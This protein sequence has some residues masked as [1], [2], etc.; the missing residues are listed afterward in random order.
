MQATYATPQFTR[1]PERTTT[2]QLAEALFWVYKLYVG[3]IAVYFGEIPNLG[4]L[5]LMV[6]TA[7]ILFSVYPLRVFE[8][9]A[10]TLVA[11]IIIYLQFV[12]VFVHRDFSLDLIIKSITWIGLTICFS[13]FIKRPGFV[14]R[15]ILYMFLVGV[16]AFLNSTTDELGRMSA[17]AGLLGNANTFGY[18]LGFCAITLTMWAISAKRLLPKL[19]LF[20]M[21]GF[22]YYIALSSVS[23]GTLLAVAV[24]MFVFA[25]VYVPV[26]MPLR[27]T[28]L[29]VFVLGI[30]GLI[31]VS[32]PFFA[33]ISEN[34]QNRLDRDTGRSSLW[35]A[36]VDSVFE[37]PI[38]GRGEAGVV[39]NAGRWTNTS[40]HNPFLTL[41]SISGVF[42]GFMLACLFI[43]A[44][45]RMRKFAL[46]E[47][48]FWL[49]SLWVFTIIAISSSN[50][51]FLND[52]AIMT[53]VLCLDGVTA[54]RAEPAPPIPTAT[55]RRV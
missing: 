54:E 50:W 33:S 35:A 23:R 17:R 42:T 8:S 10:V 39:V 43:F 29:G 22:G 14:K 21:A 31:V 37:T 13:F 4:F 20:G 15:M 47:G 55:P 19:L 16:I 2:A 5:M 34:Y 1:A 45:F 44:G 18:W 32:T 3:A 51:L 12:L 48:T 53:I 11:A 28:F 25:V 41:S 49:P 6:I 7:I 27:N 46:F 9:T 38:L 52:W 30:A 24:A 40:A 36:T 26:K